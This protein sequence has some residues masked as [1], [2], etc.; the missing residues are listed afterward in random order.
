MPAL[1]EQWARSQWQGK[2][3]ARLEVMTRA[4]TY[5]APIERLRL[6]PEWPRMATIVDPLWAD[7][8]AQ[9]RPVRAMLSEAKQQLGNVIAEFE[10]RR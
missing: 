10:S 4:L 9:R 2:T 6:H 1:V 8:I 3:T 5:A 7:V